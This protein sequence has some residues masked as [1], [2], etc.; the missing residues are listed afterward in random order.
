MSED[1]DSNFGE[2]GCR[3]GAEGLS[4]YATDT[5]GGERES[6]WDMES[7]RNFPPVRRRNRMIHNPS[8]SAGFP[9][10]LLE[11]GSV[12]L[13][14]NYSPGPS[15]VI[16][17][18]SFFFDFLFNFKCFLKGANMIRPTNFRPLSE[19]SHRTCFF[20]LFFLSNFDIRAYP[21]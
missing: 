15:F 3:S 4:G 19:T 10:P 2:G 20:F 18:V 13:G 21:S 9:F 8:A 7:A 17:E 1:A 11:E 5:E 12:L 16:R 14:Q 6:Q